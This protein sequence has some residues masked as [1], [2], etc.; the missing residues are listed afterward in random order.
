MQL[1]TW[2]RLAKEIDEQEEEIKSEGRDCLKLYSTVVK[3]S[4]SKH[5]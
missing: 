2:H 5:I 1:L 4:V 3:V